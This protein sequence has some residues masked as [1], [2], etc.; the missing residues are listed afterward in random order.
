MKCIAP[1]C[2]AHRE[3]GALFCKTHLTASSG[4]RGGWIS[5]WRRAQ[6]RAN[7]PAPLDASQIY[8][9]LWIGSAPPLDRDLPE[10][11]V[12]FLCAV[13]V[14]PAALAFSREVVRVPIRD[15]RDLTPYELQRALIGGKQVAEQLRAGR[16]VLVTCYAGLNR[17]SLVAMLGLGLVTRM[18]PLELVDLVRERRSPAAL[19]NPHFVEVLHRAV[20]DAARAVRNA[21]YRRRAPRRLVRP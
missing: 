11:D 16:R 13:E 12:L 19:G 2:G 7:G 17:S 14:Q 20:G 6:S 1:R 15:C 18:T 8:K 21:R 4:T 5:A 10:F 9:R 3:V